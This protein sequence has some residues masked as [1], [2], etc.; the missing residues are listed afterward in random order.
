MAK[1]ASNERQA[2][3]VL[4]R[5]MNDPGHSLEVWSGLRVLSLEGTCACFVARAVVRAVKEYAVFEARANAWKVKI[6]DGRHVE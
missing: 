5:C 2:E 1:Q 4:G 3:E 6:E